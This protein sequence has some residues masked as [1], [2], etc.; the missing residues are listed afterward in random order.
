MSIT[1]DIAVVGGGSA[2]AV[3]AARLAEAGAE[4]VLIEAGPDYGPF[5]T[6]GWPEAR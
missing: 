2:G 1:A 6:P 3:I 4:V 5:G